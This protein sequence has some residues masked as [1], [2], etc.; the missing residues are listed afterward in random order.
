MNRILE[1]INQPQ[2]IK[3]LSFAEIELLAKEIRT[4]LVTTIAETGGHLAPNLGVV[5]LTLAL[6]KVYNSPDDK[7]V[8]DVGHQSYVHKIL[9]GRKEAFTTLRTYGGMSGF[10]KR[11]ESNHDIYGTG[12]SSTSISAALGIALARDLKAEKKSVVAVIGDGSLTGGMAYEAINN[13]GNS[14]TSLT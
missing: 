2:D 8:W 13:A 7:I 1:T 11:S 3:K 14:K 9:T 4:L 12:H 5:E 10:P 6:H